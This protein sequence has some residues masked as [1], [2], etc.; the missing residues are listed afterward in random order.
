MAELT[1]PLKNKG[2]VYLAV[3]Q[4][5]NKAE[6]E[7][8]CCTAACEKL[9]QLGLLQKPNEKVPIP[10]TTAARPSSTKVVQ[11]QQVCLNN[12]TVRTCTLICKKLPS[13]L[14]NVLVQFV[15]IC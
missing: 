2:E 7:R 15:Y 13:P 11:I 1:V 12:C 3:G 4:G 14:D 5:R 8:A 9:H 6:A 10:T